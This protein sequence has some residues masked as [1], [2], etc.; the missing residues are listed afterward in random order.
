MYG[1]KNDIKPSNSF[2][3]GLRRPAVSREIECQKVIS[4]ETSGHTLNHSDDPHSQTSQEEPWVQLTQ[5]LEKFMGEE[6]EICEPSQVPTTLQNDES[7]PSNQ[8][9]EA[10]TNE[11]DKGISSSC[12][13]PGIANEEPMEPPTSMQTA[14]LEENKDDNQTSSP[15]QMAGA[16]EKGQLP[17]LQEVASPAEQQKMEPFGP[18]LVEKEEQEIAE[19]CQKAVAQGQPKVP[20]NPL[21]PS[22]SSHALFKSIRAS[23][24]ST[25]RETHAQNFDSAP[26]PKK[27]MVA[28]QNSDA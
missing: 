24:V 1:D 20:P 12:Q 26:P 25:Q 3:S 19:P 16:A 23:R 14:S 10:R 15:N 27:R 17:S 7:A 13:L 22:S 11:D 6:T 28:K 4:P 21:E 5:E 8:F 2:G 9:P 18:L